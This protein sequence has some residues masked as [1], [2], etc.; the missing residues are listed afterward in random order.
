[1]VESDLKISKAL[2]LLVMLS[3]SRQHFLI[4]VSDEEK[5]TL[6]VT[7]QHII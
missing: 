4:N 3:R 2:E 1:M 5:A 6:N 7:K